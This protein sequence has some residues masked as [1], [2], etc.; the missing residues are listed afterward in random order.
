M[1]R[2]L[3]RV[4]RRDGI[5]DREEPSQRS[6]ARAK[7]RAGTRREDL[8]IEGGIAGEE[9]VA[10]EI[11]DGSAARE[12]PREAEPPERYRQSLE[13]LPCLEIALERAPHGIRDRAP[14]VGAH[15]LEGLVPH[16]GEGG[17]AVRKRAGET[18]AD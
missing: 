3:L 7:G 4:E 14:L 1:I 6:R 8:V 10:R 11:G 16:F 9:G 13:I 5:H 17:R 18:R 2:E 15:V 12:G